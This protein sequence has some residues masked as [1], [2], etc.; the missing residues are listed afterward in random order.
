MYIVEENE[1]LKISL[2]IKIPTFLNVMMYCVK[3]QISILE[4]TAVR[5]LLV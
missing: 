5:G 4:L 2:V 3:R 1:K